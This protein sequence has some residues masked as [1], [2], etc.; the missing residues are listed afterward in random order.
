MEG[1]ARTPSAKQIACWRGLH[2]NRFVICEALVAIKPTPR[3]RPSRR[4]G[5]IAALSGEALRSRRLRHGTRVKLQCPRM[6]PTSCHMRRL[7]AYGTVS[8]LSLP[9]ELQANREPDTV[10]LNDRIAI[11]PYRRQ[12]RFP[13]GPLGEVVNHEKKHAG[14]CVLCPRRWL[15]LLRHRYQGPPNL[16]NK[17]GVS[18]AHLIRRGVL[19]D[20]DLSSFD[21]EKD[22]FGERR[23]V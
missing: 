22:T 10:D 8:K 7:H 6:I 21:M 3:T 9:D 17:A 19:V 1:N 12:I 11:S 15:R 23:D 13:F 5:P 20:R 4:K 18:R 2:A 16:A 14:V